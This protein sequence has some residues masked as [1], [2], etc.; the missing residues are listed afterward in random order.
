MNEP[1]AVPSA[2]EPE[3][4][5]EITE[6]KLTLVI[7][8]LLIPNQA[9]AKA[10][11]RKLCEYVQERK[12]WI[13][14]A[15]DFKSELSIAEEKLAAAEAERDAAL[16]ANELDRRNLHGIVSQIESEITGKMWLLEGRGSYEWDDD[17]YRQEFGWAVH[18]IQ[19][20]LELLRKITR[21]LTNSPTKESGVERVRQLEKVEAELATARQTIER[22][23]A[24]VSREELER[25]YSGEGMVADANRF[26]A[27]IAARKDANDK[28][29]A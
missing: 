26:N 24:P 2:G 7:S 4:R 17:K 29:K 12:E 25:P 14:D 19:E 16:A 8:G 23:S 6:G 22:L 10:M 18:A 3:W 21:D 20:K 28:E 5:G 11:A 9:F 27:L 1:I 13:E 15:A